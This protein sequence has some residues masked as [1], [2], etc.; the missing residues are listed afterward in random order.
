MVK[1][2]NIRVGAQTTGIFEEG[3][4]LDEAWKLL[5]NMFNDHS[6]GPHL[7]YN[8]YSLQSIETRLSPNKP[9]KGD[10]YQYVTFHQTHFELKVNRVEPNRNLAYTERYIPKP[11]DKYPD[12]GRA[13]VSFDKTEFNLSED[14][15]AIKLQV[16][17]YTEG[18]L[19]MLQRIMYGGAKGL[20]AT[21]L[22][23][24][25][26]GTFKKKSQP[27]KLPVHDFQIS[28]DNSYRPDF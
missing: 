26:G 11:T 10:I 9:C 4:T 18:Y 28:I 7:V 16:R 6:N 1:K 27:V 13:A 19:S 3:I 5:T 2:P 22:V 25:I 21:G 12:D 17:R 23:A 15:G 20:A 24:S 14:G 8:S